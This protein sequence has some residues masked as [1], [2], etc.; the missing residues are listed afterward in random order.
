[1]KRHFGHHRHHR[2][3]ALFAA[4]GGFGDGFGEGFGRRGGGRFGG[5]GH[6]GG[7]GRGRRLFGHGDLRLLALHLIGEEPRHGYDIIR[8]IEEMTGGQYSP[9]PGAIYP[10]LALLDEQELIAI[11]DTSEGRKRYRLTE[12]GQQTLASDRET[13]DAILARIKAA[14]GAP[15]AA[16]SAPIVRAM[17]N[18]K[19]AIRLRFDQGAPSDEDAQAMADAIDEAAR[20]IERL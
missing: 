8:A 17:E 4:R 18:L 15:N 14:S 12:A 7:R 10:V 16:R 5:P 6:P 2:M 3:E 19:L 9:S 20:R 11:D 13:V 1:M